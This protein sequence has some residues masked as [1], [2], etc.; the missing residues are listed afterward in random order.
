MAVY[1]FNTSQHKSTA[2]RNFFFIFINLKEEINKIILENLQ[3]P[4]QL[5]LWFDREAALKKYYFEINL[6]IIDMS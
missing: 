2:N 1:S 6:I 3:Y 5:R 4:P